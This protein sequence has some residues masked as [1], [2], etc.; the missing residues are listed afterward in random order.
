MA[1]PSSD[2]SREEM[3]AIW[4]AEKKKRKKKKEEQQS[5]SA[6]LPSRTTDHRTARPTTTTTSLPHHHHHHRRPQSSVGT[7][8]SSHLSSSSTTTTLARNTTTPFAATAA[9]RP[10]R[11]AV[12][13]VEQT[14]PQY[15]QE[16]QKL[17]QERKISQ[18]VSTLTQ[19]NN[20]TSATAEIATSPSRKQSIS[21]QSPQMSTT[22]SPL[23]TDLV[24]IP[25]VVMP[26]S[27]ISSSS[28][29]PFQGLVIQVP[30]TSSPRFSMSPLSMAGMMHSPSEKLEIDSFVVGD[31]EDEGKQ[32]LL[33]EKLT[34]P[35]SPK[36]HSPIA[37]LSAPLL[38]SN[39]TR[40]RT[41]KDESSETT[42]D[43]TLRRRVMFAFEEDSVPS[44]EEPRRRR[45][46]S[47]FLLL[48]TPSPLDPSARSTQTS[49]TD[50]DPSRPSPPKNSASNLLSPTGHGIDQMESAMSES[51]EQSISPSLLQQSPYG[52]FTLS[53]EESNVAFQISPTSAFS[54]VKSST[55]TY[56]TVRDLEKIEIF[57][58]ENAVQ[59]HNQNQTT[60]LPRSRRR[61]ESHALPPRPQLLLDLSSPSSVSS[62]QHSSLFQ[63]QRSPT[64]AF[65]K[66]KQSITATTTA[67]TPEA[68]ISWRHDE[69]TS[70]ANPDDEPATTTSC[71]EMEST[72][73]NLQFASGGSHFDI[74]AADSEEQPIV[75]SSCAVEEESFAKMNTGAVFLVEP[76]KV[77][78]KTVLEPIVEVTSEAEVAAESVSH[79]EYETILNALTELM[80]EKQNL[81]TQL[82]NMRKSYEQRVTPFRNVFDDKRQLQH[83]KEQL[84]QINA[85]LLAQNQLLR[86]E[87][88]QVDTM[89]S[90][91]QQQMVTSLQ[92][93]V[94]NS[95]R[96]KDDLTLAHDKIQSLETE[97]AELR[98]I[99]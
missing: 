50:A 49:A 65:S 81:Q 4:I 45:R 64:S 75:T 7:P 43:P 66:V 79:R 89:V 9:G 88:E 60:A 67:H 19:P 14:P 3:L 15:Q 18:D 86:H 83:E 33:K 42:H 85:K 23:P 20:D 31:D 51:H 87:K 93:A 94:Q 63:F 22:T 61:R 36:D 71:S 69:E 6:V 2:L 39:T 46:G 16:A 32:Q 11:S 21:Q 62:S 48:P 84:Q 98:I 97:L 37:P 91:L 10:P 27:D 28:K 41:D 13:S 99:E 24:P 56:K 1:T 12:K 52:P 95:T 77:G 26:E 70:N 30:S 17:L 5:K 74:T 72:C 68:F 96:L 55:H 58:K 80:I 35:T 92:A 57:G 38:M 47:S 25:T 59:R 82:A 90:Q 34:P 54:K 78:S 53:L 73:D 40:S 76:L 44:S 29:D 8:A